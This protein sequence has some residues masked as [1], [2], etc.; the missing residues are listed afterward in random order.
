M[1]IDDINKTQSQGQSFKPS[2][3]AQ[4]NGMEAVSFME[5]EADLGFQQDAD[6]AYNTMFF[7][8]AANFN[9]SFPFQYGYFGGDQRQGVIWPGANT[10]ITFANGSTANIPTVARVIGNLTGITDGE[11]LYQKFCKGPTVAPINFLSP[12]SINLTTSPPFTGLPSP[13]NIT[14]VGYPKPQV[15]SSDLLV[16]GYYLN[17]TEY[18]DVGVL[19]I[20]SFN[21]GSPQEFQAV[22]QTMLA[23]MKRDGKN[24]LI[25]DLSIN[26]GG[27]VLQGFDTFRQLF[28]TIQDQ[29]MGRFRK[30]PGL[31]EMVQSTS[32]LLPSPLDVNTAT[33]EQLILKTSHYNYLFDQSLGNSHFKSI[34]DK[35]DGPTFNGDNYSNIFQ[36]DVSW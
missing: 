8:P 3:V 27:S 5:K 11:S 18:K 17:K 28:P 14:V 4:I 25:I 32:D 15:V 21:P 20:Q 2:V 6:T 26:G 31:I 22:V 24:K 16:S 12:S 9:P 19:A 33:Y 10:N 29:V 1:F 23:E 34:S 35:F 13:S 7:N 36:F 30:Q